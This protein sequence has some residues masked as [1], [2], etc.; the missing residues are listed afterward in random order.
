MQSLKVLGLGLL[1]ALSMVCTT[2]D[3]APSAAMQKH[4]GVECSVCHTATPSAANVKTEACVT[5]HGG[6][7]DIKLPPN[8]FGKDAHRS[9]H[10]ADLVA[11]TECHKEHRESRSLCEDCHRTK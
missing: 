10:Y 1:A 4:K 8:P 6:M 5:C 2:A 9:P 3:A 11:C 7:S